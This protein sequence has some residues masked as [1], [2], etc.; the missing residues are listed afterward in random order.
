MLN[1]NYDSQFDVL[2]IQIT[3]TSTSY[4]DEAIDGLVVLRDFLTEEI[5]GLTIFGFKDKLQLNLLPSL[6][7][8]ID[9]AQA[10]KNLTP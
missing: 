4:G 9:V 1:L 7:V 6:P 8:D 5:T 10:F 3:N 2:Y